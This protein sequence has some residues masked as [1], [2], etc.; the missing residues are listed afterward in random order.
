[1]LTA[2]SLFSGIGGFD[3]GLE[4]AGMRIAW[5][6]EI[7]PY[8]SAILK[9]H[10]PDVPNFGDIRNIQNPPTV[11]VLCGGFPCQDISTAGKGAG[12]NGERSGL[13]REYA[14]IIG[15]VRPRFVLVENVSALLSRG[16]G[17]VLG[18]LAALGFDAEWHCIPASAVG[19]PHQR[20]RIWIVAYARCESAQVPTARK[21]SAIEIPK[22][23]SWWEVEPDVDRMAD[24]VPARLDRLK[25]LGNSIVPQIA[26]IIGR[27]ILGADGCLEKA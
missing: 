2:G 5:Q 14:R 23:D 15:E 13:W 16:L 19:A 1:M 11:D 7:D 8:A 20:D 9:K 22:R 27:E 6:S 18:D 25:C 4:R 12:I 24:G 10:W 26:E 17:R 3:L 21:F